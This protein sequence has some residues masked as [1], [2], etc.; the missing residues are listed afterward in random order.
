MSLAESFWRHVDKT[1][2]HGPNGECWL[3]IGTLDGGGY[4]K[5]SFQRK[6]YYAHRI[7]YKLTNDPIPNGMLICHTCDVRNCVH[8]PHL[9]SGTYADNMQDASRKGRMASGERH[10]SRLHPERVSSGDRNGA[11]IHI[12]RM[13]RGEDNGNASLTWVKV[14]EIRRLHA[15]ES[16]SQRELARRFS[17]ARTAIKRIVRD[18]GW[19]D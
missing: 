11:R 2:G 5:F 18:E 9:F 4:G 8:P 6:T 7:A 13:S 17:V 12:E 16:V 3:W 14:R 19:H 1:P 10:W 15:E